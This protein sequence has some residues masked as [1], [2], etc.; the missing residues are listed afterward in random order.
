MPV[1]SDAGVQAWGQLAL[2][3]NWANEKVEIE[4]VRLFPSTRCRI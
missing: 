1:Q 3:F 4:A 2:G